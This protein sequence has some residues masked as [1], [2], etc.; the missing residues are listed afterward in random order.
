MARVALQCAKENLLDR[1][2]LSGAGGTGRRAASSCRHPAVCKGLSA[3]KTP[4]PAFFRPFARVNFELTSASHLFDTDGDE[5]TEPRAI[6]ART[7]FSIC[8]TSASP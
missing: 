6:F 3:E 7:A 8:R 4:A 5:T 1:P 2:K